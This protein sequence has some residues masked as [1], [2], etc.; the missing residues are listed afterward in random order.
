LGVAF[1]VSYI[2]GLFV[3]LSLLKKH[4]GKLAFSTFASH[5]A[6]LYIASILAM[7]PLFALVYFFEWESADSSLILRALRLGLILAFSGIFYLLFAKLFR[8]AEIATLAEFG[9]GLLKKRKGR[10]DP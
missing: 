3:T 10:L 1:S 9:R 5:H 8:V 7:A 6:K 2:V 4:T